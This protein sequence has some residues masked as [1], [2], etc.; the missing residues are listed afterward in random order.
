MSRKSHHLV[1]TFTNAGR[2]ADGR[3]VLERTKEV[4][5]RDSARP[6]RDFWQSQLAAI[7]SG[8][9]PSLDQETRLE[10]ALA[11]LRNAEA[12]GEGKASWQQYMLLAQLGRW[13]EIAPVATK[14]VESLQTPD[15]VRIAS[16]ALYNTRDFEGC[17]RG[18]RPSARAVFSEGGIAGSSSSACSGTGC[19]RRAPGS[20]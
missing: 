6:R 17:L 4:F 15:A 20:Y 3:A 9:E 18:P 16:H 1:A 7:E 14:L 10:Q 2:F 5:I 13:E 11:D 19:N 12:G 8:Q